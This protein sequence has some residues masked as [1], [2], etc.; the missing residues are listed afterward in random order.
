MCYQCVSYEMIRINVRTPPPIEFEIFE[1]AFE[2]TVV[3]APAELFPKYMGPIVRKLYHVH[4]EHRQFDSRMLSRYDRSMQSIAP[5]TPLPGR[6]KDEPPSVFPPE[7]PLFHTCEA[8]ILYDGPIYSASICG[9][10][11]TYTFRSQHF[12]HEHIPYF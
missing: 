8:P 10:V 3:R 5:L 7:P 2:R 11:A 9:T 4:D 6:F 1:G 12:C